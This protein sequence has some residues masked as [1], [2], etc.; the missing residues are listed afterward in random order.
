[1]NEQN[2]YPYERTL[3]TSALP[4]SNGHV[5]LGHAAGA[6]LPADIWA[7]Y[8]RMS[9]RDVLYVC[10][11]DEH[12]V[13]ITIAAEKE[14]VSPRDIIDKYHNSNQLAF[15]LFGISFDYYSRTSSPEHAHTAREFF[16]DCLKQGYLT[17]KRT[18]QF[19]DK[20]ADMFLP[21]RYVEGTCPNCSTEGARGDQCDNCGAYYNQTE[22][23]DP[24]SLVSGGKPVLKETYHWFL[25]LS[26]FQEYLEKYIDSKEHLWKDNVIQQ[27]RSWLKSGLGERSITRDLNWGIPITGIEGVDDEK[28]EGKRLYVWF[29]A[30]L[31]YI[32][33]TKQFRPD[34]WKDYWMGGEE[35]EYIAFIGKD[36]IVFHTL[37]FPAL[38]HAGSVDGKNYISPTNVPANEFLNLEKQKFSKSRN[39]SIGL[40]EYLQEYNT[41][42]MTD[43]LRYA[44]AVNLPESKDSDFT[45]KDFQARNNN[46]LAAIAGNFVNRVITFLNK[47]Y[48]GRLPVIPAAGMLADHWAKSIEDGHTA[49]IFEQEDVF[50]EHEETLFASIAESFAKTVESYEKFRFRDAI[51][52]TMDVA[53]AANKYFNDKEPW[54]AIKDNKDDAALTMYICGQLVGVI[55]RVLAPI[56]P[57]TMAMLQESLGL[58]ISTGHP[59]NE[60]ITRWEDAF[61][62]N[63]MPGQEIKSPGILFDRI[64]DEFVNGRISRLGTTLGKDQNNTST[65]EE[66]VAKP[67]PLKPEIDFETFLQ[68]DLRVCKIIEAEKIKKSKKMLKLQVDLGNETKQ[69]L[70]G[71]GQTHTPEELIG[72]KAILVANLKPAKL[73]GRISEGMLLAATTPKGPRLVTLPDDTPLGTDVR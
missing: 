70:A 27:T 49:E 40:L 30:V 43:A 65:D 3:I 14:G 34:K 28:A 7:R 53:R 36:N 38:L 15:D 62:P 25:D 50:G 33:A 29:D 63:L 26:Q 59:E 69:V 72:K 9:G 17:E 35:T 42:K 48:E 23:I 47:N 64:E 12:G 68:T 54:K 52:A 20:K 41:P 60:N 66:T 16:A 73:M 39:W 44:L 45:W 1:M 4:Y 37:I 61:L 18:E 51:T 19:Y 10:G 46:E 32:T 5:H 8:R 67:E 21:D 6:Y 31:G 58:E 56:V 24:V 22:L 13:A 2:I 71:I 55:S 57:H 11:S